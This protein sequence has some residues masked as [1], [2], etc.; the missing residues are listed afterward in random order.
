MPD[1]A[2]MGQ[3]DIPYPTCILRSRNGVAGDRAIVCFIGHLQ[4][5]CP[6]IEQHII[7]LDEWHAEFLP[8]QQR[9]EPGAIDEQIRCLLAM[10]CERDR[11]V[12]F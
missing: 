7:L 6:I 12:T 4:R 1:T 2:P 10:L 11:N 5:E 3:A 8:Q 9:S